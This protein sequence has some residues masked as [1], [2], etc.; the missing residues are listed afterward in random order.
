MKVSDGSTFNLGDTSFRRKTLLDDYK[1]LLPILRKHNI[2]FPNW[3]NDSQIAYY[4]EVMTET[5]LFERSESDDPAKR[6]RTLTNALIKSGLIN[7][8]RKLSEVANNW[9]DNKIESFDELEKALG[10]SKD[11]LVFFRQFM[12]LRV[13][14]DSN[15]YFYPFRVALK[16]LTKYQ[17]VPEADFLVLLHSISSNDSESK[18]L[19][20]VEDY[21]KVAKNN[22]TFGEYVAE[23]FSDSSVDGFNAELL[24]SNIFQ[25]AE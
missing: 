1:T 19:A 15:N 9:I 14:D 2:L 13:Y 17:N 20:L 3:N 23:H 4:Q 16:F 11:N 25:V 5:D 18:I 12:K 8:K 22:Q 21:S 6:S 7:D 24:F 10:I